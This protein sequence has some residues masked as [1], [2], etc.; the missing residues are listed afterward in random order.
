MRIDTVVHA[1][2]QDVVEYCCVHCG[3]RAQARVA[4]VGR[5]S[6]MG[7]LVTEQ[8]REIATLLAEV[9]A[10][11]KIEEMIGLIYCRACGQ[12]DRAAARRALL[13]RF[14][15]SAGVGVV[16]SIAGLALAQ[17]GNPLIAMAIAAVVACAL[18]WPLLYVL[19]LRRADSIQLVG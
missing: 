1:P 14:A 17:G 7:S 3:H 13:R 12:R 15:P 2:M 4:V 16:A 9:D 6:I 5:A 8:Q 11:K 19:A 18:A 10:H